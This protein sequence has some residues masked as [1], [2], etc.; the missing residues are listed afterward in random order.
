MGKTSFKSETTLTGEKEAKEGKDP[1]LALGRG[2]KG[3]RAFCGS[4]PLKVGKSQSLASYTGRQGTRRFPSCRRSEE[5]PPSR[6]GHPLPEA[7]HL[8]PPGAPRT[9]LLTSLLL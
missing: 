4:L 2:S 5:H 1:F 9:S 8:A 6:Q 3:A 7:A